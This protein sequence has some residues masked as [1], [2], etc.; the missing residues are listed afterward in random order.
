M[1][2]SEYVGH[3]SKLK[4]KVG[5]SFSTQLDG[6]LLCKGNGIDRG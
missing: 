5:H 4:T 6:A 2:L 1:F 3:R